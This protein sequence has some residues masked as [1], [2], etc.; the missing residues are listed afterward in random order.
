MKKKSAPIRVVVR[1]AWSGARLPVPTTASDGSDAPLPPLRGASTLLDVVLR[2]ESA[3]PP[4][5]LRGGG[6]S[7]AG[8]ALVCLRKTVPQSRWETTTLKQML[9]GDD[10]S[11]GVLLTLDLAGGAGGRSRREAD[12]GGRRVAEHPTRRRGGAGGPGGSS[13]SGR[14]HVVLRA[15]RPRHAIHG[16]RGPRNGA[17]PRGSVGGGLAVQL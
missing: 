11:A 15:G 14:R 7:S 13:R 2:L 9:D 4:S 17:I 6:A 10:G 12:R 8:A 16:R 3:L 5:L 1:C